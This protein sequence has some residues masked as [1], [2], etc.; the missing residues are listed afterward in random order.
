MEEAA[1]QEQ[2]PPEQPS[3]Q[4]QLM[5]KLSGLTPSNGTTLIHRSGHCYQ[6][7]RPHLGLPAD[8]TLAD[9]QPHKKFKADHPDAPS[10]GSA[11][12]AGASAASLTQ[13]QLLQQQQQQQLLTG[14]SVNHI[15]DI[16]RRRTRGAL[17]KLNNNNHNNNNNNN[18]SQHHHHGHQQ[19]QQQHQRQHQ[20]HKHQQY[21]QQVINAST[22]VS[23][24]YPEILALI[25][26]K[27]EVR[28]RG[29]AAQVCSVWREAA[30]QRSAWRGVEAK[31][32]L[33]KHASAVFHCLEKRGIKRVQ[34]LSLTVRRGL[35]DVFRGVP[36]LQSLNLSGC[37]NM[38][39]TGLNNALGQSYPALTELNLSLCKNITDASLGKIANALRN[40][41]RLE[42]G[43]CSNIT[44]MGLHVISWGLKKLRRL[45][46]RSCWHVSDQGIAFLAGTAAD[47]CGTPRLE[48]LGLQD[49][50]RLSDEGLRHLATGLGDTLRSINLSFCVLITD[51]GMKH[52]AKIGSLRELDL[53]SCDSISE[54]GMAYLAEGGSRVSSLDVSFC[55]KIGDPALQHISQGL[56]NLK[57]LGLSA[58]PITD[59]GIARIARSQ[60][61]LETLHIGQCSKLTDRSV[62]AIVDN[63]T[64][65]RCIDLYG[66][67]RISKFGLEK[68]DKLRISLNLRLYLHGEEH[69]RNR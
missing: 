48:H 18:S 23:C 53:R 14:H 40:L 20:Q 10:L 7:H 61:A 35:G 64:E 42:L 30:Y 12:A 1:G 11:A 34:V 52:V 63:M 57:C 17:G 27:L 44:N 2:Q 32:H 29:R 25:F 24:L 33:R 47:D 54:I 38:S 51:A 19:Q 39:D 45:D 67:T 15:L 21:Q 8:P 28:D 5:T 68:I 66:C 3:P 69:E 37:Y 9:H 46:L 58:C 13:D 43:G 49:C 56:F 59:E 36:K 16:N 22:H 60:R 4:P 62:S 50:Q 55:D 65:L 26:S 41:E 6:L 31:L